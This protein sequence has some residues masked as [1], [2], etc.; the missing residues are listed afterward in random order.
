MRSCE[1][2]AG[3][4]RN[5]GPRSGLCSIRR[6]R[7]AQSSFAGRPLSDSW[8]YRRRRMGTVYQ[9]RDTR[10]NRMVAIKVSEAAVQRPV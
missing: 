3:T 1:R 8:R 7:C 4:T 9:A 5:C 6:K 10:L 2:P